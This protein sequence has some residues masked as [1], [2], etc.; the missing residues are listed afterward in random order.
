MLH[1]KHLLPRIRIVCNIH[2]V[3]Q[4]RRVN[5]LVFARNEHCR[6]PDQLELTPL[7]GIKLAKAVNQIHSDVKGL[8]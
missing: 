8:R 5:F 6:D 2:E 1:V 3:N 7:H 4:H